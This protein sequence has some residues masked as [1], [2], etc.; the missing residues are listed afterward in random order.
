MARR[1]GRRPA[2]KP[3]ETAIE[4]ANAL[5]AAHEKG[6]THRDLKPDNVMLT[7]D[8]RAKI[9]DFG[10][11]KTNR[12]KASSDETETAFHT[13]PN[14]LMGTAGYM[15]PEQVLGQPLDYRADIFSFG[16]LLYEMLSGQRAFNKPTV[17]ETLTAIL[18]EEP[19]ELA[20]SPYQAIVSAVF[21]ERS[22]AAV[23]EHEGFGVRVA[24]RAEFC[25]CEGGR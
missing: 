25:G 22:G 20:N 2:K 3:V 5:A 14:L 13:D 8:G 19:P 7:R 1:C 6:I 16:V 18:K 9:L 10:L 17:P 12:P 4:I 24:E 15:A 11:A 21:G 23:S